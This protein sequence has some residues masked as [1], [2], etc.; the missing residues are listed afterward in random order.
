[1]I[2]ILTPKNLITNCFCF[3]GSLVDEIS[4][5]SEGVNNAN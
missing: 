3:T 4:Y 1:M 5:C 2:G